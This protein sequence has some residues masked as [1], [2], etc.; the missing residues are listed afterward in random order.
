MEQSSLVYKCWEYLWCRKRYWLV[1][2]MVVLGL[3]SISIIFSGR[4]ASGSFK[5]IF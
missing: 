2:I 1:P 5:Y 3:I 4:I